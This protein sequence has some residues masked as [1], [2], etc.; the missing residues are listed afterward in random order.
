[1]SSLHDIAYDKKSRE[2]LLNNNAASYVLRGNFLYNLILFR[3]L[4]DFEEYKRSKDKLGDTRTDSIYAQW[5]HGRAH[6]LNVFT[7]LHEDLPA[8]RLP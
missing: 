4:N 6:F 8:V 2:D 1:M 3:S 7:S 5:K